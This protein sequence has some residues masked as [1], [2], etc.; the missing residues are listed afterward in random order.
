MEPRMNADPSVG[1][2][3][4]APFFRHSERSEESLYLATERTE[5]T[6]ERQ[7]QKR[8][9]TTDYTDWRK[10]NKKRFGH[11]EHGEHGKK[12]G[13]MILFFKGNVRRPIPRATAR[14]KHP[15]L[16]LDHL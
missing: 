6:E 5:I 16:P 14:K 1:A 2:H 11:G 9:R 3:G 7:Q 15:A 12:N 4:R 13:D 10:K 8:F